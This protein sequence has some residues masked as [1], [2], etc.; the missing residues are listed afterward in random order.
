MHRSLGGG[1]GQGIKIPTWNIQNFLN[2]PKICLRPPSQSWE[3]QISFIDTPPPFGEKFSKSI[4][5]IEFT[6]LK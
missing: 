3:T 6:M 4:A 1:G 2:L 5:E